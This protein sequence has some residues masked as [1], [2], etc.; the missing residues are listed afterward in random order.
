MRSGKWSLKRNTSF[1]KG[2]RAA[3]W[4][5]ERK[6]IDEAARLVVTP[7]A[8]AQQADPCHRQSRFRKGAALKKGYS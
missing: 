5:R 7:A 8:V 3:P 1:A 6:Q 2:E 4:F